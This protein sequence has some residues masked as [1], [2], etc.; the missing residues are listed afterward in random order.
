MHK[1]LISSDSSDTF[2]PFDIRD[3]DLLIAAEVV[4]AN[5]HVVIYDDEAINIKSLDLSKIAEMATIVHAGLQ[6]IRED[7][8][9]EWTKPL[10]TNW[11]FL[12]P[13]KEKQNLSWKSTGHFCFIRKGVIEALGGIDSKFSSIDA[14]LAELTYRCM[15]S[16]GRVLYLP[17]ANISASGS[18]SLT[19]DEDEFRF[20]QRHLG[21][22]SLFFLWIYF[23]LNLQP[24]AFVKLLKWRWV[25]RT[26]SKPYER[27]KV[28]G[29]TENYLEPKNH[30]RTYSAIIP[31]IDRYDYLDKAIHSLINN[32]C[33][34]QEIIIV[35]QTPIERRQPDFYREYDSRVR[36][37]FLDEAGQCTSRNL[38]I[39]EAQSEWLLLFEDDAE[40]WEDMIVEHFKLLENSFADA[41]TGMSLAPW[42]NKSYIPA[43]IA[44]YHNA[45]VLATGNCM[46]SKSSLLYVNGLH[47]AYN[48]GSG[49]DDDL[50]RRLYLNGK[51]IVFNPYAIMTHHKAPSGG[52]RVHGA[53][54]RNKTGLT[55]GF[56]PATELYTI[57]HYY[58]KKYH[59]IK[60]IISYL[61]T[62]QR[63]S[64]IYVFLSFILFPYKYSKSSKEYLIISKKGNLK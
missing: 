24:I 38:A 49:A 25:E 16:G 23:I 63:T 14:I 21:R 4:N 31:T 17:L 64:S 33:P 34:P 46:V 28:F 62:S 26:D 47:L 60:V 40:A 32:P 50:G 36:V 7:K 41:S 44:F 20:I 56:P 6:F 39:K 15:V 18:N 11:H 13:N 48:R 51:E 22:N 3:K 45:D 54:W 12:T 43:R 55:K 30:E 61:N 5:R 35:D 29:Y 27:R 8:Y 53:W 37:F 59:W 42:K 52:M 58:P 9:F 19:C 10:V 1:I 2:V 57:R